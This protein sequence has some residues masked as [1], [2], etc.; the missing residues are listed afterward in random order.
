MNPEPRERIEYAN[1]QVE[2]A[3]RVLVDL[4]QVLASFKDCFTVVGGWTPD[5][6]L[7]DA[8]VAHAGSIDVDIALDAEKL[9]DGRYAELINSLLDTRRYRQGGKSFQLIAEVD[10]GDDEA[11][12][13][14]EVDF[15]APT[16]IQLEKNNP[17]LLPEFRVLQ[18]DACIVAFH[19][20]V[21]LRIDG[22]M[23]R[24]A[25]NTVTLRIVS[26][27]DFL[28]M[29]AHAIGLRDK[30]KDS[31]DL[32]YCL[33]YY[34]GGIEPLAL[35][36]KPRLAE[37]VVAMAATILRDKFDTVNGF[38]P[39]QIVE[40]NASPDRERKDMEARRAYEFV[41]RFLSYLP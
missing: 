1:R 33:E 4:G 19:E 35:A 20:P 29:K 28:V 22:K 23:I 40:F 7:P 18:A 37:P 32:C 3:R 38:G 24:G 31:Y 27:P 11:P 41:Q 21:E 17:K 14:V 26:L 6:L 36:L 2:A 10:L 16:D 34:P 25:D 8:E 12:V 15:L 30:P 13:L 39:Q 9:Q 5:L